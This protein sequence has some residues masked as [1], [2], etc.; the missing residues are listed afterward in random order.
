MAGTGER[1][2]FNLSRT[3]QID[4]NT[5]QGNAHQ[6]GEIWEHVCYTSPK[7]IDQR[8]REIWLT[9]GNGQSKRMSKDSK[10]KA[11]EIQVW[12]QQI[13]CECDCRRNSEPSCRQMI[14][15]L[16]DSG[17]LWECEQKLRYIADNGKADMLRGF[18][19]STLNKVLQV[20]PDIIVW[21]DKSWEN[22]DKQK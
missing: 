6:L 14:Q 2:P 10:P 19:M 7:Q 5:I 8:R 11:T 1:R 18:V 17:T 22:W 16:E 4:N 21:A 9:V 13:C 3:A 20:Q 12:P 15:L